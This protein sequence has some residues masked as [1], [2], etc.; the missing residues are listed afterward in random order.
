MDVLL[1]DEDESKETKEGEKT[2]RERK[3]EAVECMA[4]VRDV[5]A[6][7]GKG[8]IEE[9]RLVSEEEYKRRQKN[10]EK[11]RANTPLSLKPVLPPPRL[12]SSETTSHAAAKPRSTLTTTDP[13]TPISSLTKT[14]VSYPS[15][16]N[17]ISSSTPVASFSSR[18]N[19]TP[20]PK[21]KLT[22]TK[23]PVTGP[24]KIIPP[25]EH[26]PSKFSDDSPYAGESLPRVPPASTPAPSRKPVDYSIPRI[27]PPAAE[28]P[29]ES[30]RADPL[31]V[32]R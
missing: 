17:P 24:K 23:A 6:R 32:L 25:W 26:T 21:P 30:T 19:Q 31:G 29:P 28:A 11:E 2:L 5:L 9:E 18:I 14:A 8:E 16:T 7:G 27:P 10:K 13:A 3:A 15:T 4:Y 20:Q 12:A 1:L 22:M